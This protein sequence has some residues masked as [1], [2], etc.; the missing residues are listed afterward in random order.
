MA[1]GSS[2]FGQFSPLRT[3]HSGTQQNENLK[4]HSTE[5]IASYRRLSQPQW[6]S[7]HIVQCSISRDHLTRKEYD[8]LIVARIERHS[9]TGLI[10]EGYQLQDCR[11]TGNSA[12][13]S[14]P[15]N[16]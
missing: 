8:M 5:P 11:P 9:E 16:L 10:G 3:F 7:I 1:V 15:I 12:D 13:L 14:P 6:P 2:D 4:N